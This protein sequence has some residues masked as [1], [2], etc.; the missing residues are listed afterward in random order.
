[1]SPT[2]KIAALT[3]AVLG[4][5]LPAAQQIGDTRSTEAQAKFSQAQLEQL[6]APIALHP[7]ALLTQI[8]SAST[9]PIEVVQAQRWVDGNSEL[10]GA[11]LEEALKA[12]D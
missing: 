3:F 10:K 2:S 11:A 9:Y 7:D 1:M 4:V 5:C 12:Q 8:L 6:V